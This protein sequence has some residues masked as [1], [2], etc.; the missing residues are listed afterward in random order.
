MLHG[1]SVF[2]GIG[3]LD[4][5]LRPWVRT[6]AYCE[7]DSCAQAVLAA[8]MRE[9][10]LPTAP[11]WGDVQQLRADRGFADI[12][13]GGFPCQDLSVA[14]LRRGL[15]GERS[16]LYKEIIRLSAE[17]EPTF[18]FLENVPGVIKYLP[19]IR[20]DF[21]SLGYTLRAC[22][23]SAA[24]VGAPHLRDRVFMLAAHAERLQLRQQSGRSGGTSG[25]E[26]VLSAAAASEGPSV[27]RHHQRQ[28][29]QQGPEQDE[30]GRLVDSIVASWRDRADE[31]VSLLVHGL[32]VR[33]VDKRLT[34]NACVP[35]QARQA[36]THLM[37]FEPWS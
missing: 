29:Q 4:L 11:I 19:R 21:A 28:L 2:T 24:A 3:G 7:I 25:T 34:G 12:L 8:R 10:R 33:M 18:V 32:P 15:D 14:G 23:L 31:G 22:R 36:F 5:A 26:E 35:L 27:D 13:F 30:R 16:G 17:I 37:G 6:I 9:G 1:F 20:G